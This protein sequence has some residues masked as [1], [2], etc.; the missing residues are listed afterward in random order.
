MGS[1]KKNLFVCVIS[2]VISATIAS[3]W[4]TPV[5]LSEINT[6]SYGEGTAFLSNDGLTLYFS[7]S[8][9]GSFAQM[10]QATRS[11]SSG[12]FTS[13][14]KINELAYSGG[15]V[16][17]AW[18]SPDNLHMYFLRTESG[19]A[20]RIKEST[21]ETDSSPWGNI[22]NLSTLNALG[23]V[24]Y[25]KLSGNELSIVFNY[26]V[27]ETT[28]YLYTA[29]RSDRNS[30]FTSSNIRALTELNTADVRAQYLSP[31]GLSLYFARSDSGVFHN[32][33]SARSSLTG[34]FGT[35]QLLNYWPTN[36]LL[37]C[38]SADGQTAYLNYNGDI[39]VSQIPEPVTLVLLGLG[40]ILI[41]KRG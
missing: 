39:Y 37:N 17:S 31:D 4:T 6:S 21:R 24:G 35:A 5:P 11:T 7:R 15:H 16:H 13:V 30:D 38:F 19:S 20:W 2:L 23:D 29:N 26:F 27:N 9:S 18:V 1:L 41:R 14:T 40:G 32:Y 22:T 8:H 3:A 33:L 34:T 10:Y 12:S 25:P 36:Y 28:G